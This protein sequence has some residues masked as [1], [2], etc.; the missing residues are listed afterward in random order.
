MST[1]S[2]VAVVDPANNTVKVVYVHGDGYPDGVGNCL[3]KYYNTYEKANKIVSRGSA[4]YLD[5]TLEGCAFYETKED[6][7]EEH[8]NEY[9]YMNSMRGNFAIEYIYMFR[10]NEWF[11]STM[12]SIK[13]K[14]K[15]G[16]D[17]F[18]TYWT[19]FIPIKKHKEYT[20]PKELKHGE[21]KM[22][23]NISKMLSDTF[24]ADNVISQGRKIKKLN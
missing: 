7:F 16:Y 13:Q 22:V 12:K 15:D 21:V 6:S 3:L 2:N 20:A 17:N 10:N 8:N 9:C 11:V 4:S 14:P 23:A 5:E 24:G 1:R 19:K 18:I